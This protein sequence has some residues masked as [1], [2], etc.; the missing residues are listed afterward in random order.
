MDRVL[1]D[2]PAA[3]L[4]RVDVLIGYTRNTVEEMIRALYQDVCAV[5]TAFEAE[6]L[7]CYPKK[8]YLFHMEVEFLWSYSGEG[9]RRPSPDNLSL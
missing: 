2:V 6:Q 5:P 8:S 1:R 4:Y 3:S 7:V 9:T